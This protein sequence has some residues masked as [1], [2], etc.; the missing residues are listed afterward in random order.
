MSY[1]Y[2]STASQL[3]FK[4]QMKPTSDGITPI[5]LSLIE[6]YSLG[7]RAGR[8]MF[9]NKSISN[10]NGGDNE[11]HLGFDIPIN[12]DIQQNSHNTTLAHT[13]KLQRGTSHFMCNH[14]TDTR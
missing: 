5:P 10:T 8:I 12:L 6:T 4:Q 11:G 13:H 3:G 1:V 7:V 14:T 2:T 9:G